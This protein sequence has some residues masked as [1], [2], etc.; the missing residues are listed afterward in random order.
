MLLRDLL[1]SSADP[2]EE[3]APLAPLIGLGTGTEE[4]PPPL[5]ELI[6]CMVVLI[7]SLLDPQL[8]GLESGKRGG[9]REPD[10]SPEEPKLKGGRGGVNVPLLFPFIG[11]MAHGRRSPCSNMARESG[12]GMGGIPIIR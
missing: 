8:G 10:E 7:S 1:Q 5:P 6:L 12:S 9:V 2:P 11:S 3:C 4:P